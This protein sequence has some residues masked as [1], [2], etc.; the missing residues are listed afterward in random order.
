MRLSALIEYYTIGLRNGESFF[1]FMI[2]SYK[3]TGFVVLLI[4]AFA[5]IGDMPRNDTNQKEI[6]Y[7]WWMSLLALQQ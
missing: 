7:L 4:I 6:L 5:T 3:M 1:P 2:Y